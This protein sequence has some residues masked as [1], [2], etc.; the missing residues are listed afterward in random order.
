M[1]AITLL[2]T[3]HRKVEGLFKNY[4]SASDPHVR[5]DLVDQM[6]KELSIHAAIE[7]ESFYPKIKDKVPGG[8]SLAEESLHEHQQVKDVLAELERMQPSDS[9]YHVKVQ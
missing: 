8:E 6:S 9:A 2:T 3:D 1:D 5:K 7:E 4:E